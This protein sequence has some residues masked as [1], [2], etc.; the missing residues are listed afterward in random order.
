MTIDI[1]RLRELGSTPDKL[2]KPVASMTGRLAGA[3]AEELT[4]GRVAIARLKQLEAVDALC[5]Q[6][7][8]V[9]PAVSA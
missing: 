3:L 1:A 8:S 4:A 2:D 5:R 7:A 6:I 9:S